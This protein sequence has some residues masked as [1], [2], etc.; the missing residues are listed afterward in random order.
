MGEMG[1]EV[2]GTLQLNIVVGIALAIC[3]I[4]SASAQTNPN[5]SSPRDRTQITRPAIPGDKAGP[6]ASAPIAR[7]PL[8]GQTA[9]IIRNV[10]IPFAGSETSIAVNP[11]NPNEIVMSAFISSW[12]PNAAMLHSTDAGQTWNRVFTIPPPPGVPAAE[13]Q[14]CPCDQTFD[15]GR[16]NVVFGTFL[17]HNFGPPGGPDGDTDNVY[18][19]STNN[20]TNLASWNWWVVAGNAQRTDVAPAAQNNADQPWLLRNRGTTDAN[21]DNIF[22]AY[23]DFSP[24]GHADVRV[25][26][27]INNVPPQFPA[28]S[29]DPA[30]GTSAAGTNPGSRLATDPR[31]G[32]VYVLWENCTSCGGDPK[33]IQY[34]LN[35][36]TD[37]GTTWTLN[38][39]NTGVIVA[40][41]NS[42]QP[43]PKFG[44]VNALLG[45]VDHAAVDPTNGDLYYVYGDRDGAGNNRIAIKRITDNGAGGVTI[46]PDPGVI[47]AGGTVQAA[48]PQVS[49]NNQG[50]VAVFY[51]TF[52][53]IVTGFPQFTTWLATSNDHGATF[54]T[55]SILTFLATQN[56]ACPQQPN[57]PDCT[58][59]REFGDYVQMKSV[60]DCFYGSYV[61]NRAAF[62]GATA[63]DDPVFFKA[64]TLA[65]FSAF[66]AVLTEYPKVP[67]FS[68]NANFTLAAGSNGINP[69]TEPV[70]LQIGNFTITIPP[71]SF[72]VPSPGY[73]TF[74][75]VINGISLTVVIRL[76]SPNTFIFGVIA[77]NVNL[78]TINP[79]GPVGI[80]LTIGDDSGTTGVTPIIN[81]AG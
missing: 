33:T 49:V 56:D 47:V 55:Q 75:G 35:R 43:T 61:A 22:V 12:S 58:R 80:T 57:Q 79:P 27:S 26:R 21:T 74:V 46:P 5:K 68:I 14:N 2:M 29:D 24:A 52:N 3:S 6:S 60:F 17:T 53:G 48:L 34:M 25:A 59:Q 71:N 23:D 65:Q 81:N 13:T 67:E 69:P 62:G 16:N 9:T 51:Y 28:G 54:N 19:G 8:A 70:T 50:V 44:T 10:D 72:S 66:N 78:T 32:W 45:G 20:P 18:S 15:Y 1:D 63:A 73:F 37:Q 42:T 64:C 40:T 39:S 31:N 30:V 41:A 76:T 4:G 77:R 36:S 38:G 7:A 11:A